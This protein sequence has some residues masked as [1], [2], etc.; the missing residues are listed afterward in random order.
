M[1]KAY[2]IEILNNSGSLVTPVKILAPIN[3]AG[4]TISLT[5]RLSN[6]GQLNFRV[7]T[8]DPLFDTVGDVFEPYRY[9]VRVLRFGS[10][11]WRGVIINNPQRNNRYVECVAYSY[12]FLL[13]KILIRH[14]ASVT[15]GDGLDN[16]KT[17]NS[18]TM[19]T[20]ITTIINNA[21]A[22]A[23][24]N[25]PVSTFTIG[26]IENPNYPANYTDTNGS[27]MTGS[28]TF[29]SS[30]TLQYDY[31]S[32]LYVIG[33]MAQYV[34][35]DFEVTHDKVFNFKNFIG[36]RVSNKTF[37]YGVGGNLLD[38]NLPR[39]GERMANVLTGVA[40]DF[41]NQILHVE[42]SDTASVGTYGKVHDVAA[43]IDVKNTNALKSR[44]NE[45]LRLISTPESEVHLELND[46]APQLGEYNIGD[47]ITIDID[48]GVVQYRNKE[49]RIVGINITVSNNGSD[50]ITLITNKPK[51]GI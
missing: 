22:D 43:Y 45:E 49:R 12:L 20:A 14:D 31:R 46:K 7:S 15:P 25:N 42:Q 21:I 34:G 9:H 24:S 27:P 2:Q 10:E 44:L 3:K 17:F 41:G 40:A 51:D 18:G 39:Y 48:D 4:D 50:K 13:K 11:V 16:Y 19:D 37:R 38:Y 6:Y 35:Y 23:G 8:K 33:S 32:A 28:W 29:S 47:I 30:L 1:Q 26:T 5:Y 36:N